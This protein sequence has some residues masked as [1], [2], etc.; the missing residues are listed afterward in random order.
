MSMRSRGAVLG[1]QDVVSIPAQHDRQ[2][3]A[4]RALI[5]HDQDA[6]RCL[7]RC[8]RAGLEFGGHD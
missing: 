3:L 8:C 5:V 6:R 4:H 2:Q 1:D 7:S